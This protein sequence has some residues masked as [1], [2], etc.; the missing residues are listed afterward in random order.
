VIVREVAARPPR[1]PVIVAS[2]DGWVHD[3]ADA[4]GATVVPS[5]VLLDVLRR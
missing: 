1:V 4:E 3:H 2:S 5:P